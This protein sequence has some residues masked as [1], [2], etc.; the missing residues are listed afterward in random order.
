MD[1]LSAIGLS[2]EV[3]DWTLFWT[4]FGAIGSTIGSAAT[5]IAVIVALWQTKYPY[6]KNLKLKFSD[7]T[8]IVSERNS[9]LPML[10]SLD[11]ANIG[12][13]DV[14]LK[15][16]G[17]I[18]MNKKRTILFSQFPTDEFPTVLKKSL[19][20][21]FPL[22][23]PIDKTITLYFEQQLFLNAIFESVKEKDL[24]KHQQ[25]KIYVMDSTGK[26]Y[27]TKTQ[28]TVMQLYAIYQNAEL[29]EN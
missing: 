10:V 24:K 12:N 13:R 14:H 29:H 27:Y 21:E 5:T 15:E 28:K 23:L 9:N 25:V 17:I 19:F 8:K 4:A 11:I 26:K 7:S 22:H 18:L 6:K 20:P 3:P 2:G 1:F 16:W